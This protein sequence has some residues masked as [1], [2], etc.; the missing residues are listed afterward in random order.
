MIRIKQEEIFIS[1]NQYPDAVHPHGYQMM[2]SFDC[3]PFPC[4][5]FVSNKFSISKTVFMI[6]G[7]NTTVVEY[8]NNGHSKFELGLTPLFVTRDYHSLFNGSEE[9]EFSCQQDK[10]GKLKIIPKQGLPPVYVHYTNGNFFPNPDWY[11][12]FEYSREKERG[13][14]YHENSKS[15]GQIKLELKV[16]EKAYLVFSTD[17]TIPEGI[18]SVWKAHEEL[19]L[20]ALD[21]GFQNSFIRDLVISG[22]Q[23]LVWRL[24]SRSHTLIAGYHWFTDWGRDTMIAMRGLVIATGK[25]KIAESIFLTFLQYLDNGMIPNRFPDQ[26]EQPEYNTL[27]ATLWLFIALYEYYQ[28]FNDP[29]FIEAI[30]PSL[31]RIIESHYA[32]TRY[33]IHVT[34]EGLLYGGEDGVQLTWMDAKVNNHVVTPRI[35]CAVEIN[36]LW[37]NALNI[38]MEFRKLFGNDISSTKKNVEKTKIAFQK[39]FVN[40]NA[41]LH[42]L[43]ITIIIERS[44]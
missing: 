38:Y 20:R 28:K 41:P 34:E 1:T 13:L 25:K 42:R 36:A 40:R 16:G 19:R 30:M 24:S 12:N 15:I 26:G 35:G 22:D 33:H 27:D 39:Y 14:D 11:E 2:K 21:T 23:F 8:L 31:S 37:Y 32:G 44:S 10:P 17:E 3:F 43:W 5:V 6:Y 7:S 29:A 18:P 9:F 4:S